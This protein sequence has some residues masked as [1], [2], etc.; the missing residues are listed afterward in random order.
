[1]RR[2]R[3]GRGALLGPRLAAWATIWAM[4]WATILASILATILATGCGG[5][6]KPAAG[7][8]ETVITVRSGKKT[9]KGRPFYVLVRNVDIKT[10]LAEPYAD[11]ADKVVSPDDTVL[12]SQVIF[13]GRPAELR[14]RP[15]DDASLSVY[16]L[17][18]APGSPWKTRIEQPI[19]A[20]I[21]LALGD[22]EVLEA[23]E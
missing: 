5:K 22:A 20:R 17:F 11:V 19:P 6:H 18:T 15:A 13:P 16:F 1:M 8:P 23:D 3:R 2:R 10:Y 14:L 12:L 21:D 4:G 7:E 9:N